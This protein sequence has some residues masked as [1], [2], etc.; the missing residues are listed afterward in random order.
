[1]RTRIVCVVSALVALALA[2]SVSAQNCGWEWV[3][4]SPPRTDIYR[5]KL[6]TNAFVGVGATGTIIRSTDGFRWELIESGAVGDLFGVD[7]GAGFF[8]AVGDGIVLQSNAG[9]DWSI[10]YENADARLVDVEFSASRYIAVGSGL[11][12]HVLTSR[13]GVDWELVP[14]PWSGAADSITGSNDGFYVAVGTEVWFSPDGFDWVYED[15]A[16]ATVGFASEAFQTKITGTDLFELDRIDLAWTG[17]RLLWAGGSELWS[18]EQRFRSPS[19]LTVGSRSVIRG[20]PSSVAS[21]LSRALVRGGSPRV[22]S[23]MS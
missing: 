23:A 20:R 4:P 21:R 5:L 17:S 13:F 16:P 8:V 1:V 10:V 2:A 14:V 11:E 9:Y 18:R 3:N 15:T 7:W 6:E 22:L 19:A 12:G